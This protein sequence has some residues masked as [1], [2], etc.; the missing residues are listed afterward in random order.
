MGMIIDQSGQ[1]QLLMQID[2]VCLFLDQPADFLIRADIQDAISLDSNGF[3]PGMFFNARPHF[4]VHQNHI[5][6]LRMSRN[7]DKKNDEYYSIHNSGYYI[8]CSTSI[9][10][11]C[12]NK[13]LD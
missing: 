5:C 11:I 6:A 8:L 9:T 10:A 3:C 2:Y 7:C 12:S 13:P 4:S 1:Y